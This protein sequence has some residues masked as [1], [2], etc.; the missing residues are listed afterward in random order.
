MAQAIRSLGNFA[1]M[2]LAFPLANVRAYG[3]IHFT[4]GQQGKAGKGQEAR[5]P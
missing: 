4:A 2:L 1:L 3:H 5:L